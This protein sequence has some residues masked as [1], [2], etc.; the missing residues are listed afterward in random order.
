[1]LQEVLNRQKGGEL[2]GRADWEMTM[3]ESNE[4]VKDS[5][6]K[7]NTVSIKFTE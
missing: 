5:A 3:E 7:K 6:K 1:M 2:V 4:T